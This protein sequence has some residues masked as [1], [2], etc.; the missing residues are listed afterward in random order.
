M[1]HRIDHKKLANDKTRISSS[2]FSRD[3]QN[4]E[5]YFTNESLYIL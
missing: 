5:R 4:R 1:V 2:R 3:E